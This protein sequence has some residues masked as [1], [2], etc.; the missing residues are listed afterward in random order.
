MRATYKTLTQKKKKTNHTL[1]CKS[2]PGVIVHDFNLSSQ[3]GRARGILIRSR[4]AKL[5]SETSLN[6]NAN[7]IHQI[8]YVLNIFEAEY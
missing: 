2:K 7:L 8:S 4:S 6:K 1:N 5:H 3:A